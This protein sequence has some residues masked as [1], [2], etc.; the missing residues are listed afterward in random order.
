LEE[1]LFALGEAKD[2]AR[3]GFEPCFLEAAMLRRNLLSLGLG[4]LCASG[5]F[6]QDGEKKI[7][8]LL[9]ITESKGFVH[10]VV[11]RPAPDKFCIVEEALTKLGKDTGD[12]EAVC[13]QDSRKAITAEN[14]K[15]YD[16]VF[17]YTTGDLPWSETQKADLLNY[18]K[19]GKGFTGSHCQIVWPASFSQST[20]R[21][22]S[23]PKSPMPCGP[24]REV[25]CRSTPAARWSSSLSATSAPATRRW[26]RPPAWAS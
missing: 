21:N 10:E 22:A 26:R 4:V 6:A 8:K 1:R 2:Y 12:F 15:Q 17:F 3:N 23:G 24:G 19:S 25:T 18:V 11:K 14:L 13:S 7:P 9:V 20:N 5:L 16:A